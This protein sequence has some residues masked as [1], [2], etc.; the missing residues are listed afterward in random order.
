MA[1]SDGVCGDMPAAVDSVVAQSVAAYGTLGANDPIV[2][3]SRA[4]V[5][6]RAGTREALVLRDGPP[7]LCVL[8][9]TPQ[10][11]WHAE[12]TNI[13]S[14][15]EAMRLLCV[16]S[17]IFDM[18]GF[19]VDTPVACGLAVMVA[20]RFVHGQ[21][22]WDETYVMM[23]VAQGFHRRR[24]GAKYLE[25]PVLAAMALP[26]EGT[27]LPLPLDWAFMPAHALG[28]RLIDDLA[29]VTCGV[30]VAVVRA[31]ERQYGPLTDG[32]VAWL[33]WA[34]LA[35]ALAHGSWPSDVITRFRRRDTGQ[36]SDAPVMPSARLLRYFSSLECADILPPQV[37][38]CSVQ[39]AGHLSH[40]P[41]IPVQRVL[42]GVRLGA[43]LKS[44]SLGGVAL[45][46]ASA[47]FNVHGGHARTALWE[48]LPSFQAGLRCTEVGR[49][50]M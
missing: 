23:K 20:W 14:G 1:S 27:R 13:G 42:E 36:A 6:R 17:G 49:A 16:A 38:W 25:H 32:V 3:R 43:A 26:V 45:Q 46:A 12:F 10:G 7:V 8:I 35:K 9:G 37:V 31:W 34:P 39:P 24:D 21:A 18:T 11:R 40:I 33:A 50:W 5:P 29:R 19:V 48:A 28:R 44:Q 15:R 30:S 4:G 47:I 41:P 22:G 2:C